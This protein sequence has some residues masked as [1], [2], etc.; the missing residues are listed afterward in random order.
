M[1]IEEVAAQVAAQF[2]GTPDGC[3]GVGSQTSK[4]TCFETTGRP[5]KE[6]FAPLLEW[7]SPGVLRATGWTFV[8]D[9]IAFASASGFAIPTIGEWD[10][11]TLAG[12]VSTGTHGGSYEYGS[13]ASSV[14]RVMLVDGKGQLQTFAKGTDELRAVL[15]SFGSTG[16]I[17]ALDLACEPTFDLALE[18]RR[19][20][21]ADYA[22]ELVA[23]TGKATFRAAVWESTTEW[24]VDFSSTKVTHGEGPPGLPTEREQR[25]GDKASVY[26]W[27]ARN[28]RL[29]WPFSSIGA[30]DYRGRYEAMLAPLRGDE[31]ATILRRRK[32]QRT[33]LESE[34]AIDL[35]DT[36]AFLT[37]LR[38]LLRNR[39]GPD[40]M[41]GLRPMAGDD[42]W[43]SPTL[44]KPC[45]W[46][47]FFIHP[48]NPFVPDLVALL[49]RHS[50][51]P[52]WGK[53][54]LYPPAAIS[55]LYPQWNA[56][57]AIRDRLDPDRVFINRYSA[58]LGL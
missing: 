30:K 37:E 53:H 1:S 52:H 42:V 10:G 16:I 49:Q 40:R 11:Q 20:S 5:L 12:A 50:A 15:S 48:E 51:R 45:L 56:Y 33:P 57:R 47:S 25:F 19:F 44:G 8:R 17:V 18:R 26:A 43:L 27:V 31:A 29:T 35:T 58:E 2:V 13:L 28:L 54:L 7:V 39:K 55:A 46:V 23:N 38:S 14:V 9:V 24:V 3:R 32:L 36:E 4:S 22:R 21:I 34:L 6:S 41:I